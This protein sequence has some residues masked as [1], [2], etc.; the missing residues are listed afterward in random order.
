MKPK[1]LCFGDSN[2][3]GY[4][5][6]GITR[7]DH[8]TRWP[9]VLQSILAERYEVIENGICGRTTVY[10][11]PEVPGRN[12]S[13]DLPELLMQHSPLELIIIM[14]GT[15]DL[16]NCYNATTTDI[17]ENIDSLVQIIQAHTSMHDIATDI[18]IVA[19]A[20]L[21]NLPQTSLKESFSAG[22]VKS[23]T[24]GKTISDH[25]ITADLTVID[26][27]SY[28]TSSPRDGIHLESSEHLKLGRLLADT[29]LAQQN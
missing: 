3:W 1:I 11:D 9:G 6:D 26:A 19:P 7:Y 23:E 29:V 17:A 18:I 20:P 5:P 12:G 8:T 2:T 28:I 16:K 14:L 13:H 21:V 24:L 27:G 10:N 25:F 22:V 15:N 4:T